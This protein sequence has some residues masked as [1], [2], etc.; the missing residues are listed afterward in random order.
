[1]PS[2]WEVYHVILWSTALAL[3]IPAG[4]FLVS[5]LFFKGKPFQ[6]PRTDRIQLG[7]RVNGRYFIAASSTLILMGLGILLIPCVVLLRTSH[8]AG[9]SHLVFRSLVSILM[10]SGLAGLGLLYSARKGDLGW[11]STYYEDK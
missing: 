4:N 2:G 7:R 3:L 9:G 11:L 1:M 10:I 6:P 8:D 5:R